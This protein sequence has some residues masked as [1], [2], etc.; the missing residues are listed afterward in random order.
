MQN[1]SLV[2][3][4]ETYLD[5]KFQKVSHGVYLV[6]RASLNNEFH[7]FVNLMIFQSVAD[8]SSVHKIIC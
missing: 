7:Q 5:F 3:G 1:N 2:K 6:E 4:P 8:Q